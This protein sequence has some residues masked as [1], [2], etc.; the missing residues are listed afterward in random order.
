MADGRGIQFTHQIGEYLAAA[1]RPKEATANLNTMNVQFP[2]APWQVTF[3]YGRALQDPVIHAWAGREENGIAAQQAF[4]HRAKMNGLAR[5]GK[6]SAQSEKST[7]GF[8][9]LSRG[10]GRGKRWING[11]A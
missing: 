3:S 6:W 2:N 1:Y 10:C 7:S 11:S 9:G 8:S 5:S 4:C